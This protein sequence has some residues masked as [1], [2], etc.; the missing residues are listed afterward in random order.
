MGK[1]LV[2][3]LMVAVILGACEQEFRPQGL[4]P[5]ASRAGEELGEKL[6]LAQVRAH[7]DQVY[8]VPP[9]RRF[10]LA[11]EELGAIVEGEAFGRVEAQWGG[12]A[13]VIR[14]GPEKLGTLPEWPGWDELWAL[15]VSEARKKARALSSLPEGD[16]V[17]AQL[18]VEPFSRAKAINKLWRKKPSRWLLAE[19]SRWAVI[20]AVLSEDPL[21]TADRVKAHALA[22]LAL[23]QALGAPQSEAER[24][25]AVEL[26][27]WPPGLETLARETGGLLEA[28]LRG[29]REAVC[30]AAEAGD[31]V[32]RV[33][34]MELLAVHLEF[35]EAA[36]RADTWAASDPFRL[37]YI[38]GL[39]RRMEFPTTRPLGFLAMEAATALAKGKKAPEGELHERPARLPRF[40]K[41]LASMSW[42]SERGPL[43]QRWA[44]GFLRGLFGTGVYALYRYL[45]GMGGQVAGQELEQ[46]VGPPRTSW[47]FEV[48]SWVRGMV[49]H[50]LGQQADLQLKTAIF[51]G[52]NLGARPRTESFH[53]LRSRLPW[54][55]VEELQW[56][57]S[58][59]SRFDSRPDDLTLL[60]HL[61][62]WG[63]LHLELAERAS[64]ALWRNSRWLQP[65]LVARFL[66]AKG[67]GPKV[68]EAFD[69]E[70]LG[71]ARRSELFYALV[72]DRSLPLPVLERVCRE[73][74]A[75]AG[76][77]WNVA[78][79]WASVY[80][81]RGLVKRGIAV[82][83][84]TARAIR[85]GSLEYAELR[86][87]Q[88]LLELQVGEVQKALETVEE[89][90]PTY[91]GDVL[92]AYVRALVA[93]GEL[94]EALQ[95][96]RK[97][98]ERYPESRGILAELVDV[99]WARREWE[100]AARLLQEN[101]YA[102]PAAD[103][104]FVLGPRFVRRFSKDPAG[105]AA[106]ARSLAARFP[107]HFLLSLAT[108][109]R[110]SGHQDLALVVAREAF[111]RDPRSFQ[112][113]QVY[114]SMKVLEGQEKAMAWLKANLRV[115]PENRLSVECWRE[116]AYEVPWMGLPLEVSGEGWRNVW[117]LR[118]TA[119]ALGFTPGKE[120][121]RAMEKFL[122]EHRREPEGTVAA[123][124]L[125]KSSEQELQQLLSSEMPSRRVGS[126]AYY[127]GVAAESRGDP[128]EALAWHRVA[129]ETLP[130]KAYEYIWAHDRLVTWRSCQRPVDQLIGCT[131]ARPPWNSWWE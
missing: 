46:T 112:A 71:E 41:A 20:F 63:L 67:E 57:R 81:S 74:L 73:Y 52:E 78:R 94:D 13:W 32:H 9:D 4:W 33:Y 72:E 111:A 36:T 101:T 98:R 69:R 50:A 3:V 100:Q 25:L 114:A 116:K 128:R 120:Q 55:S 76:A 44:E 88:A 110:E 122:A 43:H 66:V 107:G 123:H 24:V 18:P 17:S 11:L 35:G 6:T 83:E 14:R 40:E 115:Q 23:D 97:A 30:R 106:A 70:G 27:Y 124:L 105:A 125:G 119:L 53:T 62:R 84:E 15:V 131:P 12:T 39:A 113:C 16:D 87:S 127:L 26:G 130:E 99:H 75:V 96:A 86:A 7:L 108:H 77:P 54:A 61:A 19:A 104:D 121:A 42:P 102:F 56:A 109:A 103:W 5:R 64:E 60:E 21:E 91:K 8:R 82:L 90:V 92:L 89:V 85:P 34:C 29:E 118:A 45:E 129:V 117:L 68:V 22:L 65:W 59:F 126:L 28:Y 47:G 48:S 2:S 1:R 31:V 37:A 49:A 80:V 93:N 10:L 51:Y 38:R 95:W 79:A 58:T